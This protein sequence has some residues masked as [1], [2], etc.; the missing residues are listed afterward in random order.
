MQLH[1][2]QFASHCTFVVF[3]V[4]QGFIHIEKIQRDPV[5]EQDKLPKAES[6]FKE[7]VIPHILQM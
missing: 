4:D 7:R 3:H 5:W 6:F 2:C 1:C